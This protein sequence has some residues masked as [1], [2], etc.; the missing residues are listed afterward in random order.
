L[1]SPVF[2]IYF[3]SECLSLVQLNAKHIWLVKQTIK[4]AEYFDEMNSLGRRNTVP[5]TRRL[6]ARNLRR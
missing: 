2:D 5:T 1:F 3:I 4:E 6:N